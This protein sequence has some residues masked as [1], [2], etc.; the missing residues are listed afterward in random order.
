MGKG[1]C[2]AAANIC[3]NGNVQCSLIGI[4]HMQACLGSSHYLRV[5]STV[6]ASGH[7]HLGPSLLSSVE[8]LSS[9]GVCIARA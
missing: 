8:K 2:K 5:A 6:E 3:A 1:L 7:T 4:G 9:F